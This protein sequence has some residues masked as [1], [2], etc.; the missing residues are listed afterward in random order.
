MTDNRIHNRI[1]GR[2]AASALMATEVEALQVE[3][4]G[5]DEY[6]SAED[7]VEHALAVAEQL[8]E[9]WGFDLND[10]DLAGDEFNR[11]VRD[12]LTFVVLRVGPSTV[13]EKSL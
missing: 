4:P 2:R 8:I 6:V 1:D 9:Q 11:A 5:W 3:T 10:S 12:A 7:M 13:S